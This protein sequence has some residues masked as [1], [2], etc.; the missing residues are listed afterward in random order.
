MERKGERKQKI[1]A[2]CGAVRGRS[3]DTIDIESGYIYTY[4]WPLYSPRICVPD[5]LHCASRTARNTASLSIHIH[6]HVTK[7]CKERKKDFARSLSGTIH[8]APVNRNM[9]AQ[10]KHLYG[11]SAP[12]TVRLAWSVSNKAQLNANRVDSRIMNRLEPLQNS[13]LVFF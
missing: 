1:F 2:A 12:S 11:R 4:T 10:T 13:R 9:T 5:T 8:E 3:I 7:V 6:A